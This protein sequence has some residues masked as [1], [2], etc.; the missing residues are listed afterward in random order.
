MNKNLKCESHFIIHK[1]LNANLKTDDKWIFVTAATSQFCG[2][3]DLFFE[4]KPLL[5]FFTYK[6]SNG[7][8]IEGVNVQSKKRRKLSYYLLL[9]IEILSVEQNYSLHINSNICT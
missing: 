7:M 6:S 3:Q 1:C 8:A 5:F 9:V 2:D 4:F